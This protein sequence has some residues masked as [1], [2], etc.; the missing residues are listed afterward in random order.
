MLPQKEGYFEFN[1]SELWE[2]I[3][4]EPLPRTIFVQLDNY[5]FDGIAN[6]AYMDYLQIRIE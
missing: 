3:N 1:L 5:D 4:D 2:E 6:V